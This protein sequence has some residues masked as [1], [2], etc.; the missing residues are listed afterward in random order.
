MSMN[1]SDAQS[2]SCRGFTLIQVIVA[3]AVVAIL[4]G[5]AFPSYQEVVRKGKRTEGRAALYLLM[6]QEER[7]YS[8]RH[9]YIAFSSDSTGPDEKQFK[10]FSGNT[11]SASAYEISAEACENDTIQN[12]VRLV[13]KPGTAKVDPNFEDPVCGELSL[14]STGEKKASREECWR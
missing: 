12:C 11:P 2:G 9:S 10:W 5:I 13:A 8:Q 14:T 7:F 6:Q 1:K 4:A 3:L